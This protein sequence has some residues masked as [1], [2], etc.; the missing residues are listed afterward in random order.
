M[1]PDLSTLIA[2]AQDVTVLCA[3]DAAATYRGSLADRYKVVI[4]DSPAAAVGHIVQTQSPLL[5]VDGDH[6]GADVC[7][8]AQRLTMPAPAVLVTLS[9]PAAAA[10]VVDVCDSILLK[11]F[12]A[13]LLVS[14]VARLLRRSTELIQHGTLLRNHSD[15]ISAKSAHLA[16]RG[17]TRMLIEWPTTSCPYCAHRPVAMFDYAANRQAWYACADCR[18]AWIAPRHGTPNS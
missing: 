16:E 12:E 9:V 4:T 2:S 7:R 6:W 8:Q 1:S 17:N 13:N 10:H 11:P 5:I 14:R 3:H 15:R 18:K